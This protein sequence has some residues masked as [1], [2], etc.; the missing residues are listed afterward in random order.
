MQAW[1]VARLT[2]QYFLDLLEEH[3]FTLGAHAVL[4]EFFL[5]LLEEDLERRHALVISQILV[6][7]P[8]YELAQCLCIAQFLRILEE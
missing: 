6:G 7:A 8:K 2:A 3:F 4:L 5:V 1:D